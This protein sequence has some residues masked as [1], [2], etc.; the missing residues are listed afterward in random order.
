[1][2]QPQDEFQDNV[3]G[4]GGGLGGMFAYRPGNSP[5]LIGTELE[6]IIYGHETRD[7][8]FSTTIPDITVE[9]K[10]SNNIVLWNLLLRLQGNQGKFRGYFS[11]G[12][13]GDISV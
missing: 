8:P 5:F 6:Y 4:L 2:S 11:R 13:H 9:V 3:D 7:E 12:E 1:M 10:T